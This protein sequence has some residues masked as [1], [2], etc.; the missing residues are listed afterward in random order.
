[1]WEAANEAAIAASQAATPYVLAYLD[2]A[3]FRAE[4]ADLPQIANATAQEILTLWRNII[5]TATQE[6]NF[7]PQFQADAL[8]ADLK[9]FEEAGYI[10]N[11][12]VDIL[13]G[14]DTKLPDQ[15]LLQSY[16][17]ELLLGYPPFQNATSPTLAESFDRPGYACINAYRI[18]GGC[19]GFGSL[20]LVLT[21]SF[22]RNTTIITPVD[23]GIYTSCCLNPP[24]KYNPYGPPAG[25]ECQQVFPGYNCSGWNA[26]PGTYYGFDHLLLANPFV[27][28]IPASLMFRRYL[29]NAPITGTSAGNL[30]SIIGYVESDISAAIYFPNNVSYIQASVMGLLG[31]NYTDSTR[32]WA[33]NN[34]WPLTWAAGSLGLSFNLTSF[35]S[36][37]NVTFMIL[38]PFLARTT[39]NVTISDADLQASQEAFTTVSTFAAQQLQLDPSI[40][41]NG[42]FWQQIW[43]KLAF[44]VSSDLFINFPPIGGCIDTD[45]CFSVNLQTGQCICRASS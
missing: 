3:E 9:Q 12:Y 33:S 14:W 13:L 39:T 4:I 20:S 8:D 15:I 2:S 44:S 25:K 41:Q 28:D 32:N 10:P 37:L 45:N 5:L 23:T 24:N 30:A 16:A 17:E 31:Y 22:V 34:S 11:Y 21:P 35:G 6:H 29:Q 40:A 7:T 19:I 42:A 38:D 43:N 36:T 1:M 26:I 18:A 27:W